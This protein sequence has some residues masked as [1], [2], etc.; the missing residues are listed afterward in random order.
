METIICLIPN[1]EHLASARQELEEAGFARNRFDILSR[2][3]DVWKRLGG[4]QKVRGVFKWAALGA[5]LSLL[6]GAIYG[7]PV[8]IFNCI[9]MNCPLETGII[10][11]ALVSLFWIVVGAIMGAII[12]LDKLEDDLYSYV[13]GVRRGEVLFMVEAAPEQ[14]QQAVQI[15][16]GEKGSVIHEIHQQGA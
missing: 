14:T 4:H 12:G 3:A 2:P 11:W 1:D 5:L 15:L 13:E 16:R 6:V 9:F 8:G 10:L 7:V